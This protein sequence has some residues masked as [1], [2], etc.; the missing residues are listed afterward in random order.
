[1]LQST[2]VLKPGPRRAT[3]GKRL[4]PHTLHFATP[5][6]AEKLYCTETQTLVH[7]KHHILSSKPSLRIRLRNALSNTEGLSQA[8][9]SSTPRGPYLERDG[10]PR[11]GLHKNLHRG[12]GSTCIRKETDW[13]RRHRLERCVRPLG[14]ARP[15]STHS[16]AMADRKGRA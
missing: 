2:F 13:T 1:M 8:L 7:A 4:P 9:A 6:K 15:Q 14:R 11:K 16:P 3:A 5:D 10:L 12:C